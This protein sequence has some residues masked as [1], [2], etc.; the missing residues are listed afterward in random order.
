MPRSTR[1]WEKWL[2]SP[3]N[4]LRPDRSRISTTLAVSYSGTAKTHSG[5]R[6]ACFGRL[7]P[8][9]VAGSVTIASR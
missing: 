7:P 5:A 8:A 6:I 9:N 1:R 2:L 3:T 4:G